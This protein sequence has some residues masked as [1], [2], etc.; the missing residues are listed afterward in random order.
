MDTQRDRA[1]H[2]NP[3]RR[4][5]AM[6]FGYSATVLLLVGLH[7][8]SGP[9]EASTSEVA[10]ARCQALTG[11]QFLNLAD[12]PTKVSHARLSTDGAEIFEDAARFAPADVIAQIKK[13]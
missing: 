13:D 10:D 5:S 9:V 1:F 8:I 11:D 4:S 12:A 6:S 2:S 7:L 3:S